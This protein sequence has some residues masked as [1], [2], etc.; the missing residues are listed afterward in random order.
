LG[1]NA[2][3]AR[4][5]LVWTGIIASFPEMQPC[6]NNQRN[7][8]VFFGKNST[9]HSTFQGLKTDENQWITTHPDKWPRPW[10]RHYNHEK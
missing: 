5:S 8:G 2:T 7:K 10:V 9:V 3:T 6:P 1:P 4:V